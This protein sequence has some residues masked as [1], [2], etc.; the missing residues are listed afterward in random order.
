MT[1]RVAMGRL[2]PAG[3][4]GARKE[5]G[6]SALRACLMGSPGRGVCARRT[7]GER[8]QI[9]VDVRFLRV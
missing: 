3:A 1:A 6:T 9:E 7:A 8:C 4:A 5:K 2:G